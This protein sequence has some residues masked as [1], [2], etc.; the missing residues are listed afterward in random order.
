M[1]PLYDNVPTRRFPV[2][3]VALIVINVIVFV[4]EMTVLFG[5]GGESGFSELFYRMGTI[6]YEIS[7][8]TDVPPPDYVPFWLTWFSAM[9]LHGGFFH[10]IFNMLFLWIFG[11]N[12]EDAMGRVKFAVFYALCG[13]V[14]A[15]AQVGVDLHE[16]IPAIGASGA[17][18]GV[19]GAYII[20][21]PRAKVL[22]VVPLIIFWQLIWVPAW[23]LL[24][25]WF[26]L[27]LISGLASL[28]SD[29]VDV[30]YFEHIGGFLAGL[31]LVFALAPAARRRGGGAA[32]PP[33]GP[34]GPP[35]RRDGAPWGVP[36]GWEAWRPR[37]QQPPPG[38]AY[39]GRPWAPY[40][41]RW[42]R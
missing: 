3:T 36:A 21:Y 10:I 40:E 19:L 39:P 14:A 11:N 2:V 37:G 26:A 30:A 23:V 38:G 41:G 6:P 9:F 42:G 33:S 32:P 27:Q 25:I 1:I 29:L 4:Y 15:L 7:H 28:G 16:K 18:A 31:L 24:V 13:L 22:S 35:D 20:L 8:Q 12:V 17:I 34:G 5:A